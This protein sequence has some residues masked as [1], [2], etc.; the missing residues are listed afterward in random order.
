MFGPN[1][2]TKFNEAARPFSLDGKN[3][4]KHVL[5]GLKCLGLCTQNR[6]FK[7][8][9][10]RIFL[11]AVKKLGRFFQGVVTE[12]DVFMVIYRSE[13]KS[14]YKVAKCHTA[15]GSDSRINEKNIYYVHSRLDV[16]I[17]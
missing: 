14:Y 10:Y 7:F 13:V 6:N 17:F 9:M 11:N 12:I 2:I 5:P 4:L 3:P 1:Y 15:I 8:E 16:D